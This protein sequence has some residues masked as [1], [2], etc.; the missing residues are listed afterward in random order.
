MG[1][2][3]E[4]IYTIDTKTQTQL[5]QMMEQLC[6]NP[7]EETGQ[8]LYDLFHSVYSGTVNEQTFYVFERLTQR[9]L[10]ENCIPGAHMRI[11]QVLGVIKTALWSAPLMQYPE[12]IRVHFFESLYC[13]HQFSLGYFQFQAED[14]NAE[15]QFK[16][17]LGF[18]RCMFTTHSNELSALLTIWPFEN[19][20]HICCGHCGN[21]IHSLLLSDEIPPSNISCKTFEEDMEETAEEWDIFGS[22][23]PFLTAMKEKKLSAFLVQ[24]YGTHCC[25][26]CQQ[27]E[28]VM[29]SYMNWY[30]QNQQQVQE[31]EDT[32]IDW[33]I[34]YGNGRLHESYQRMLFFHKMAL[35]YLHSQKQ[36]SRLKLAE[37]WLKISTDHTFLYQYPIQIAYAK[38]AVDLLEAP[39]TSEYYCNA[40]ANGEENYLTLLAEAYRRLGIGYC[41]DFEHGENNQYD[42]AMECYNKAIQLFDEV[43]GKGNEKTALVEKNIAVMQANLKEDA[44]QSIGALKKQIQEERKKENPDYENI[45]D[46]YRIIADL[47]AEGMG[48]YKKAA[49]YYEYYLKQAQKTY[50][51][52]SDF[53][54]DCYEELAEYYEADGNLE[55][56]CEYC[57]QALR[58]NIREMGRIYLLPPIFKGLLV[59]LLTKT[60]KIDEDDKFTRSMSASDSYRHVGELYLQMQQEEK[61]LKSFQK[62]LELHNWVLQE[63]TSEKADLHRLMGDANQKLDNPEEAEKEYETAIGLYQKTIAANLARGNRP[64][65]ANET[66]ECRKE[67]KILM[68]Q[69]DYIGKIGNLI[70]GGDEKVLQELKECSAEPL[71]YFKKHREQYEERGLSAEEDAAEC[72]EVYLQ[73]LGMADCLLA[74]N[75][76]CEL[77]WKCEKEDFLYFFSALK[78]METYGMSIE[79]DWFDEEGSIDEWCGIIDEKWKTKEMCVAAL[80]IDSDSYVI[81]PVPVK[82]MEPL[83]HWACRLGWNIAYAKEM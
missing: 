83:V 41:A 24:L 38:R 42:L 18:Y 64:P 11:F 16:T 65:F 6:G 50:G 48:N 39:D 61:A 20:F 33:L 74:N 80:D 77:D 17:Y 69:L 71:E 78:G 58:I 52:E 53:V 10:N 3:E 21:D 67:Q 68:Q 32:L 28:C 37:C 36:P 2:K 81:F 82:D 35:C 14:V 27:E 59:N 26:V 43:L 54:A 5:N 56:A 1:K 72:D 70:S 66:E 9:L 29:D 25:S 79:A 19:A 31:P 8:T 44:S 7:P 63:P 55:Q 60:G 57:K 46:T 34:D 40:S 73:W 45:G 4:F 15:E 22:M 30:Y 23:M 47:Y 49:H 76:V 75:Y 12:N 51:E 13:L 62:A